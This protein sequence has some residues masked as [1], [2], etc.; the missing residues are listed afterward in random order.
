MDMALDILYIC[1]GNSG[2]GTRIRLEN[3]SLD[4]FYLIFYT[5]CLCRSKI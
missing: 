1:I 5:A 4:C 3:F 2:N